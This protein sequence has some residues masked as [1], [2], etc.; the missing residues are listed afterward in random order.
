ML[1]G[2]LDP[3]RPRE[4]ILKNGWFNTGDLAAMDVNGLI[5]IAGRKKS[6]IN[7]AG[8]KVFPEEVE[9]VLNQHPAVK[10]CLISSYM[11]SFLGE[12]V[13]ADIV[14]FDGQKPFDVEEL[15]NFCRSRLSPYKIP[16]KINFVED[17]PMTYSQKLI[18]Y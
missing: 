17:L 1:D 12:R 6:M 11:H 2:Y 5:R 13:Q 9:A 10:L 7:V 16:Q 15:I 8:N 14:L 18:R 3:P 4:E